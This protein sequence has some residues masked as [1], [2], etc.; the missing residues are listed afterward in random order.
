MANLPQKPDVRKTEWVNGRTRLN[1]TNLTAGVNSNLDALKT[2]V[3]GV[4]DVLGPN[5]EFYDKDQIDAELGEKVDKEEG[6]G[7][8]TEDF[9]TAEKTKLDGIEA[10]AQKNTV[11]SVAGKTGAV[12]LAKGDV[13]L[14][15]VVNTGD[16]DTPVSGGTT[17]FTTGGAY[18]EL[19]KKVDK[20]T[21]KG[22]STNDF[23]T[24]EKTK[25]SGIATGAQVNVLEGVQVN[26]SDLPINDKK[27]NVDLSS[28]I[29]KNVDDLVNYYTKSLTYSKTEVNDLIS[30][31]QTIQI[32]VVAELPQTGQSNIIY[33]VPHSHGEGDIY[34]EYVWVTVTTPGGESYFEKI[35]NTDIDLS[36]YSTTAEMNAAI[37]SAISAALASYYTKAET[38]NAL[39]GKQATLVSGT[40]IKTINSQSILGSGNLEINPGV[41]SFA[42]KTGAITIGSG[43]AMTGNELSATAP[44]I[45]V[46]D[47]TSTTSTN[48]VQ[49]KVI[50]AAVN[51]KVDKVSGKGLS[52]NDFTTAEKTK[53]SGIEEGAQVNAVD[54][55]NSKTG[56][57]VLAK[58]DVGLG[59]VANTGDSATPTQ[60]GTT[61]FTTGGAYTLKTSIDNHIAN[62]SNPHSVSKSQV[63]LGSVVNTGDSATP[64]EN[65]TTK[66]TTGG[67][68]T[69]KTSIDNHVAD[70]SNPH[71]V[72]KAQ[73]GLSNV[74][75]KSTATIKSEFTGAI[76]SGNTGFVTGDAVYQYIDGL[77][78]PMIFKGTL[79][80]GGTISSLPTASSAN[81]GFTYKVITAGTYASQAAK[82]GD[83]FISNGSAWVLIP[84]GDDVED[85]WRQINVNGTSLLG[86]GISTGV[87]NFKNGSNVSISGSGHDITISSSYNNQRIKGNGTGFGA[88]AEVNIVGAGGTTV[89]ASGTTITVTSNKTVI[90]GTAYSA[91]FSNGVLTFSSN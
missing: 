4:I 6:K 28:F 86:T 89:S 62:T 56:V 70:T 44:K 37:A 80:T 19:N 16:S 11:T 33:L 57:V 59:N 2:A 25:L 75:N 88:N 39:G 1:H 81:E 68:Y 79:G 76:A 36:A 42:T 52:T 87:V 18:T 31:I 38:D 67:A 46:D 45:D 84:S 61:K 27:V 14:G 55:V 83:T 15:S 41:T 64:V 35:G 66:F 72:T 34:D 50:T 22:L 21:G 17:K 73:V 32:V 40:N 74:E 65:G 85:T 7:L 24:A 91:T 13:G 49:N 78:E 43:L 69:L 9:T 8:S 29:T 60:N 26:G 51:G 12:T 20:Q 71:S 82:V 47:A 54:S 58:G 10:G 5:G 30:S 63:G 3:D 48:P 53:L 90:D 23:T 77:P